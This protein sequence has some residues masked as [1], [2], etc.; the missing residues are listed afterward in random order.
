MN[1]HGIQNED[2]QR[3]NPFQSELLSFPQV[4]GTLSFR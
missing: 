3:T 1:K 4:L 2:N